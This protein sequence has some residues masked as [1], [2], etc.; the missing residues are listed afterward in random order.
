MADAP[1]ANDTR[2]YRGYI[3]SQPVNGLA[4]PHKVQ[5][6]VDRDYCRRKGLNFYLSVTEGSVP[7]ADMMLNGLI[8]DLG[9]LR[10]VVVFSQFV[11]PRKREVR[12]RLYEQILSAGCEL[13]AALEEISI[14]TRDD[15]AAFEAP[16][17][18]AAWL[19]A[20][21][22]GGKFPLDRS[23]NPVVALRDR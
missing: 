17:A 4:Y 7:G 1:L 13:H 21:P 6:L 8:G 10:G 12:A 14:A 15:I 2:G 22:Y 11:L 23:D 3:T 18:I 20:T 9:S 19:P 5:N 16:L